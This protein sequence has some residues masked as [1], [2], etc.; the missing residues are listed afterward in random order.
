MPE[1]V[2]TKK[3]DDKESEGFEEGLE[4]KRR[5]FK[6]HALDREREKKGGSI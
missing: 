3:K 6:F 2:N 1:T 4:W 5:Y